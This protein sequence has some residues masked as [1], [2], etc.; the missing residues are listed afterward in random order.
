[1]PE[2][3]PLHH[4]I[5]EEVAIVVAAVVVVSGLENDCSIDGDIGCCCRG[6]SVDESAVDFVA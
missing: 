1:M 3:Y 4:I 5:L 2:L 6:N